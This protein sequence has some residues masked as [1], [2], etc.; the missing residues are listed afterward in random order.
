MRPLEG[1]IGGVVTRD[2]VKTALMTGVAII[3]TGIAVAVYHI[4]VSG[5]NTD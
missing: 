4:I 3:S 5:R 1:R 2:M